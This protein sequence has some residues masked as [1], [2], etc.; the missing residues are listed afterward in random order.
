MR[1]DEDPSCYKEIK[2]E[3]LQA[4]DEI[5]THLN[6][7]ARGMLLRSK[8][9]WYD[10]GERSSKYFF[11]LEKNNAQKKKIITLRTENGLLTRNQ[12]QILDQQFKYYQ[13]LY[14]SD[15]NIHFNI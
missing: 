4:A 10:Q 14:T 8:T 13:T 15:P 11:A 1:L 2:Q 5:Q 12:K 3:Y 7:K 6:N 9:L